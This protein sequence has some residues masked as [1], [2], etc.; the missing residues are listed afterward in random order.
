MN[1][2]FG[3]K[4]KIKESK[5]LRGFFVYKYNF[6]GGERIIVFFFRIEMI[7]LNLIWILIF[8]WIF[9]WVIIEV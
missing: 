6:K 1:G 9:G 3:D 5:D 4:L 2:D 8:F 7:N